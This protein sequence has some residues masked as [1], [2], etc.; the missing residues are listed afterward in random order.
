M[1]FTTDDGREV[2]W[3]EGIMTGDPTLTDAIRLALVGRVPCSFDYWGEQDA[4][5]ETQFRAYLT[6]GATLVRLGYNPSVDLI[7]DNPD[8][9]D[10]E[11]VV[12]DAIDRLT[13]AVLNR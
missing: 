7:P 13:A 10:P 1:R 4:N 12:G 8:G 6:I 5:I 3:F 9:Y 11:G 2:S